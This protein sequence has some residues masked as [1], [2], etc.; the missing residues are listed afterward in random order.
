VMCAA[1]DAT[2]AGTGVGARPFFTASAAED[3]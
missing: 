3:A 2:G 1:I